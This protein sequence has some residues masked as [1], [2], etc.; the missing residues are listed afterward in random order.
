MQFGMMVQNKD[1]ATQAHRDMQLVTIMKRVEL[2]QK[3]LAIK[4]CMWEKMGSGLF[5]DNIV[6]SIEN[7]FSQLEDLQTQLQEIGLQERVSNLMVVVN[8]LSNLATSMG[9]TNAKTI[10]EVDDDYT[11]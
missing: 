11:D 10:G 6:E 4:M 2:T 7:L 8:V 3:M 5:K 9:L 1:S